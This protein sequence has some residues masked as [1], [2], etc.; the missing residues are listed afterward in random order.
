MESY[1]VARSSRNISRT[2]SSIGVIWRK[3]EVGFKPFPLR[4]F[5]SLGLLIQNGQ[6][7]W[8]L[9]LVSE[10]CVAVTLVAKLS[11]F[12]LMLAVPFPRSEFLGFLFR[13]RFRLPLKFVGL[14]LKAASNFCPL[15][16]FI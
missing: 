13:L 2:S 6:M 14:P 7:L 4:C 10:M 1:G 11:F 3:V 12:K 15:A 5:A 8:G 16:T 9:A